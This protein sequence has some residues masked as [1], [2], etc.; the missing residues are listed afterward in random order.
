[1]SELTEPFKEAIRHALDQTAR[2]GG[3][4]V[5]IHKA[6]RVSA[7]LKGEI[8]A[9][10]AEGWPDFCIEFDDELEGYEEIDGVLRK[11]EGEGRA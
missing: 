3:A 7:E 9:F 11:R 8:R 1:M 5:V 2:M 4:T 10:V 6:H